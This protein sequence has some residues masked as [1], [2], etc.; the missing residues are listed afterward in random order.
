MKKVFVVTAVLALLCLMTFSVGRASIFTEG[1][2]GLPSSYNFYADSGSSAGISTTVAH[3]GSQSAQFTLDAAHFAYTRWKSGDLTSYGIKLSDL[4]ASDW[5]MRT[6]GRSDLS[7]YLLFT[8]A[9][10]DTSQETMAIQF[11]MASITDNV[12]TQNTINR[13]LT[14]FHVVGDRT[15]L[16]ATEFSASGT[17]GTLNDLSANTYSGS[18]LWGDFLVTYVRVGVGQWDAYQ[19]YNGY[20][21]DVTVAPIPGAV[22]L[23]GSGLVGLVGIRRRFKK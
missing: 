1:F 12:W 14:T 21:D 8:L 11:S 10:P 7:P 6:S 3:S 15:G 13:S 9:T 5:V 20:A 4:Q 19:A 22:W 2:E 17:R 16:G 23:L 18:T